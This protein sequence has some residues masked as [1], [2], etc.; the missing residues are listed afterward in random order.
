MGG[1]RGIYRN[2]PVLHSGCNMLFN[3]KD[4]AYGDLPAASQGDNAKK[5]LQSGANRGTI[6]LP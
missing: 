5:T 4:A 6:V 3:G 1:E 2:F